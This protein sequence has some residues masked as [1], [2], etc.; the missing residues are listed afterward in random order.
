MVRA[1]AG[2]VGGERSDCDWNAVQ[3]GTLQHEILEGNKATPYVDGAT[4]MVRVCCKADAGERP[5]QFGM[6]WR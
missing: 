4:M 3:R 5:G 6:G 1:A 2:T